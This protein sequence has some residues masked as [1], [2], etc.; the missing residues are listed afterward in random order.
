MKKKYEIIQ[1]GKDDYS[2]KYK[3]KE[4]KFHSTIEIVK[5]IQE[6]NKIAR[7][8]MILD[9]GKKGISI[10]DLIKEEKK[11][12]K[13]YYDNT[14]KN[15]LE[16]IYIEETTGQIFQEELEKM[17][18]MDFLTL[19]NEIGLVEEEEIKEFSSELGKVMV[20]QFPR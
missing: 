17:L 11:D 3:D 5:K 14:N 9:L 12:G 20:G 6:A 13:I 8:N 16:K 10:K 1:N 2:L 7:I 4:I 19:L 18:G 15:E